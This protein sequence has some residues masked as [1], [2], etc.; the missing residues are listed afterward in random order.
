MRLLTAGDRMLYTRPAKPT[1]SWRGSWTR[2]RSGLSPLTFTAAW[3]WAPARQGR[4]RT[5]LT[6]GNTWWRTASPPCHE[7]TSTPV[8]G[9]GGHAPGS[10]AALPRGREES[11]R[12]SRWPLRTSKSWM[13]APPAWVAKI[14]KPRQPSYQATTSLT[15]SSE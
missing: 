7:T 10:Y 1:S 14:P 6:R 3:R 9:G 5:F 8:E 4:V 12:F 2:S 15:E 11:W 13:Q